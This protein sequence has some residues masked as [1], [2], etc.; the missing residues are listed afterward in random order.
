MVHTVV[1]VGTV[2]FP[3]FRLGFIHHPWWCSG[4]CPSSWIWIGQSMTNSRKKLPC[5]VLPVE[6][7]VEESDAAQPTN[8]SQLWPSSAVKLL[9]V[10]ESLCDGWSSSL[11]YRINSE[12]INIKSKDVTEY[13]QIYKDI[14]RSNIHTNQHKA[15]NIQISNTRMYVQQIYVPRYY[16]S[17][18][19]RR[20]T[21][22]VY[23]VHVRNR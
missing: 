12:Q 11:G 6:A 7:L 23:N 4:V 19:A 10:A 8:R 16:M 13:T 3:L 20:T 15:P 9:A 21:Y 14:P 5:K 2:V 18:C 17:S 22:I 1:E